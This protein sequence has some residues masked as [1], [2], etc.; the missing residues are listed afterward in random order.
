MKIKRMITLFIAIATAL[1]MS[2]CSNEEKTDKNIKKEDDKPIVEEQKDTVVATSVAVVEILDKLGVKLAGVPE[3]SYTLPDSTKEATK[4]GNPMNPDME[5]IKSL[6]PTVTV[7]TDTLGQ[8]YKNLFES[9]NIPSIF[10]D[11]DSVDGLKKSIKDLAKRFNKVEDGDKILKE[12]EEKENSFKDSSKS[13]QSAKNIMIVFAAPGGVN[14]L[15]TEE[16]YIGNLVKIV[17]GE[18]VVKETSGPFVSYSREALSQMNPDKIIVM[19]HAMPEKTEKEFKETLNTDAA[20]KDIKAVQDGKVEF[21]DRT[22]FGMSANLKVI[23]AL[24][25]LS[26][27]IYK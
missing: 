6:N 27:I 21:L 5:I 10:V 19:T 11:L 20:W 14:M 1:T 2:A 23:E 8:D 7:A 25:I 26:D 15:A 4:I 12:L 3:T 18:N 16:S 17:G 22:Y 13:S 24:D 9:N